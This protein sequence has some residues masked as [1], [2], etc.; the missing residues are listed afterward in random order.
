[1]FRKHCFAPL[2]S[3]EI[4]WLRRL[5]TKPLLSGF[6]RSYQLVHEERC[7]SLRGIVSVSYIWSERPLSMKKEIGI[8]NIQDLYLDY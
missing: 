6:S 5:G 3:S 2:A 4:H 1:M 8:L 7:K